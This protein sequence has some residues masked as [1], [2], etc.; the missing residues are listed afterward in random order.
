MTGSDPAFHDV[1]SFIANYVQNHPDSLTA[2]HPYVALSLTAIGICVAIIS[3][4]A[5]YAMAIIYLE[6]KI[7]AHMQDRLGPMRVGWH[8]ILQSLVDGVKLALKEDL[9][10]DQADWILFKAAPFV[11]FATSFAA[12]VVIPVGPWQVLA[13]MNVGVLY[14][15]AMGSIV[16]IGS[17]MAGWGS[18]NKFALYGAMRAVAMVV[19][20]EVPAALSILP[21]VV[22]T[23]SLSLR[24][25]AAAQEGGL[26]HWH[27]FNY[28]PF[29]F[30]AFIIFYISTLA[31][32]NRTPFDLPEA[33]SE[34]VAGYHTEYS[35]IR[36]SFFF[37]AEYAD[38]LVVSMM[39]TALFLGGWHTPKLLPFGERTGWLAGH[40]FALSGMAD[41]VEMLVWW[42]MILAVAWYLIGYLWSWYSR[43]DDHDLIVVQALLLA[44]LGGLYF[45]AP[46]FMVFMG[47]SLFLVFV[48]IWLR[49]TL[50]RFRI[51]QLMYMC[52]KVF[53]PFALINFV[54][55]TLWYG[56]S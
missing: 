39:G 46:H 45:L 28:P 38:M 22:I 10:P 25:I 19:S 16:L 41:G 8:G 24:D 55:V 1:P 29:L 49:W 50:P 56:L 44:G 6:R 9:T 7:C 15:V 4:I 52:W 14:L 51:D 32:V 36:W 35:G 13:D 54:A 40:S 30:I 26:F 3:F 5:V 34:L 37:L 53:I 18:N 31:E 20:Y 42:V 21:I 2:H 23:G 47:K 27:I 12:F 48:M 43:H 33:E 11:I 17:V